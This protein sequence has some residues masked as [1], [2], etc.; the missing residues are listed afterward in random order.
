VRLLE[1]SRKPKIRYF[2]VTMVGLVGE[3]NV[4]RFQITVNDVLV[5]EV[6]WNWNGYGSS[7]LEEVLKYGWRGAEV[8]RENVQKS[9]VKLLI[10]SFA[11]EYF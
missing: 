8:H 1:L 3:Q 11:F 5:E 4:L 6:P 9:I 2:R 10:S 7:N